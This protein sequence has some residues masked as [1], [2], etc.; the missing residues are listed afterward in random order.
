MELAWVKLGTFQKSPQPNHPW[1]HLVMPFGYHIYSPP[2]SIVIISKQSLLGHK[3]APEAWPPSITKDAGIDGVAVSFIVRHCWRERLMQT[4]AAKRS[5]PRCELTSE[6]GLVVADS[7]SRSSSLFLLV[8]NMKRNE[9]LKQSDSL[10]SKAKLYAVWFTGHKSLFMPRYK[11]CHQQSWQ[12]HIEVKKHAAW[13]KAGVQLFLLQ[14]R[15]HQ[16]KRQWP[17]HCIRPESR[18]AWNG[19][20]CQDILK[21]LNFFFFY[22]CQSKR[23]ITHPH[24]LWISERVS[25]PHILAK[26][27]DP[28]LCPTHK[29]WAG[30]L[31]R[32]R[33]SENCIEYPGCTGCMTLGQR[34]RS[35]AV[36]SA[37][38]LKVA[39]WHPVFV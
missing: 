16:S 19:Q 37:P 20:S 15:G 7:L 6:A 29:F 25:Y 31:L 12:V 18:P 26:T 17:E 34:H 38:M 27:H 5:F 39:T 21:L 3:C 10:G 30:K 33:I 11:Y 36:L 2:L 4:D 22:S 1:R 13:W 8:L 35:L 24:G 9:I 14:R 32:D 23:L 28:K